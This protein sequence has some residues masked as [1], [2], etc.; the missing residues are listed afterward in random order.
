MS[1]H[2]SMLKSAIVPA[3]AFLLIV[4]AVAGA[5]VLPPEVAACQNRKEGDSCQVEMTTVKGTC[6]KSKCKR[7]DYAN[8][9]RD[10]M[11]S[12]PTVEYDCL[13]CT[14]V[15]GGT[16]APAADL[17]NGTKNGGSCSVSRTSA[18]AGTGWIAVPWA[19]AAVLL[20]LALVRRRR[21]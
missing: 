10:M 8:W 1:M 2:T 12:P 6:L 20:G 21:R 9:N 11:S 17:G 15:D 16:T 19:A 14:T 5:D 4:P 7:L 18:G 13:L 3:F